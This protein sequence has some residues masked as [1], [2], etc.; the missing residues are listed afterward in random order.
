MTNA[1]MIQWIDSASYHD[2]LMKWRREPPGSPWFMG[3][4]G[5]H[6]ADEMR[7][8][9]STTPLKEQVEASNSIGWEDDDE[10]GD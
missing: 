7:K 6:Y 2:L 10:V 4:V 3:E 9:R 1:D 8:R 5:R